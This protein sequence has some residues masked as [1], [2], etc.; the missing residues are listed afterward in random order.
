M[1]VVA[2]P[3]LVNS[4]SLRSRRGERA[5]RH[6]LQTSDSAR[7][8]QA[9]R[10]L[11]SA[12]SRHMG[13]VHS[14]RLRVSD[15]R[16][17]TQVLE[18]LQRRPGGSTSRRAA[19][20]LVQR[21]IVDQPTLRSLAP[22][23]EPHLAIQGHSSNY[24]SASLALPS[25]VSSSS[26]NDTRGVS[27]GQRGPV[28]LR[29][30]SVSSTPGPI[31]ASGCFQSLVSGL[32]LQGYDFGACKRIISK[33]QDGNGQSTMKKYERIWRLHW[34]PFCARRKVDPQVY[35]QVNF[36]NFLNE[37][38]EASEAY[39]TSKSRTAQH[40]TYKERCAAISG[41]FELKHPD[42]QR[43]SMHPH[44][45]GMSAS[46]RRTA[47]NTPKYFELPDI[48]GILDQQIADISVHIGKT[49]S[50]LGYFAQMPISEH[51]DKTMFLLRL[52]IGNRSQDLSVINRIWEGSYAG[53][54]GDAIRGIITH[55]RYDFPKNWHSR[56]RMSEWITLGDYKQSSTGF[57]PVFHALCARSA[58]ECY[59]R[60]TVSLPIKGVV[61]LDHPNESP[62]TRLADLIDWGPANIKIFLLGRRKYH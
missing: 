28:P 44:T 32:Q 37:T 17:A 14:R 42:K 31:L 5:R 19:T 58:L 43:L 16:A 62:Q 1:D 34:V 7:G 50:Y 61:D 15:E 9:S 4:C 20:G 49:G 11:V 25:L 53:L 56:V 60:R 41:C 2:G 33:W 26:G 6:S 10:A 38:Q 22:H 51:R 36:V 8:L 55:V 27:S 48:T 39:A 45:R 59:Y 30:D 52:D 12:S 29:P 13:P 57:K 23:P 21:G 54:R 46:N 24:L 40:G 18:P 47:P 35:S 3:R